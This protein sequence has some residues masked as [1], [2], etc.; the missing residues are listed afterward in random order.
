MILRPRLTELSI[1]LVSAREMSSLHS[2]FLGKRGPTDVITFPLETDR[3]GRITGGEVVAC[4]D[5]AR[6]NA[7]RHGVPLRS[8]LLLYCLHGMLHLCGLDDRTA[9]QFSRMHRTEDQILARLGI[10][11][12]FGLS[13]RRRK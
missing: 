2:T 13:A 12:V 8:E 6:K 3:R 1:A 9:R 4:V 10:G 7:P 5:V 11:P